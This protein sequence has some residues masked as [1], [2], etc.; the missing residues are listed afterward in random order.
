MYKKEIREFTMQIALA[1]TSIILLPQKA[2]FLPEHSI[3][4]IADLHLGKTQHFRKSGI[5]MPAGSAAKDYITL[6]SLIEQYAPKQVWFLGDLFHSI[7][8][9]EWLQFEAFIHA[10]PGI[11]F[12]LIKGN[13]DIIKAEYYDKLGIAVVPHVLPLDHLL[14]SH[15]PLAEVTEGKINIAG[16]I[17]PGCV[18][19]GKGRQSYRLPCF[20]LSGQ[21]F[22]LPAFGYLTGLSIMENKNAAV[23][24]VLPERV[25]LMK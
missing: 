3:L 6:N 17:H 13:H 18:I 8:N 2:I 21:N 9:S 22:L 16:H 25:V 15:E 5:F 4:I 12:T 7:H 10:W 20:Y 23:F 11:G 14:F 19:H 1:G 24:A